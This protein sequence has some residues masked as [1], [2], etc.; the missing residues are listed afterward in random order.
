M[1]TVLKGMNRVGWHELTHAYG[2][3][4]EVPGRLSRAAWGDPRTAALDLSDLG[5]RLGEPAVFDATV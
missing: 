4:D 5:L 3:A 2:P 1:G